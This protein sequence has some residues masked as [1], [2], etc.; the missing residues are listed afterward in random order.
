MI[1]LRPLCPDEANHF[2]LLHALGRPVPKRF[3]WSARALVW[4]TA[5]CAHGWTQFVSK[6]MVVT[7]IVRWCESGM[8]WR[9]AFGDCYSVGRASIVHHS[10]RCLVNRWDGHG[11]CNGK[12]L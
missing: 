4:R 6:S 2:H 8:R 7:W 10:T 5:A 11:Y 3:G 1:A 12:W 9:L